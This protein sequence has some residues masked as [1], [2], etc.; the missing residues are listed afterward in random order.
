[1]EEPAP[2]ERADAV[3]P[4]RAPGWLI[5]STAAD[6][7]VRLH[8]HGSEDARYDPYY[9]RLA[10][11]TATGPAPD[12]SPPDNHFGL[13]DTPAPSWNPSAPG[14]AGPPHAPGRGTPMS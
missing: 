8:N 7:L 4:V 11:S 6:G 3:T 14:T 13:P 9:T 5:Q 2:A 10:Y 1:M 12:G